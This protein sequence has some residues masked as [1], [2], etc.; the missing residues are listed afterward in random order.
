MFL[1][2]RSN[3]IYYIH[4]FQENGKRTCVSTKSKTKS[5][6]LKFLSDFQRELSKK[7]LAGV[8]FKTI[9]QFRLEYIRYSESIHRPK[10]TLR[11]KGI[12]K[13]F[14]IFCGDIGL[15]QITKAQIESYLQVKVKVSRYS[16]QQHLAYLRSSF[17]KAIKDG[18]LLSNP[19][20]LVRN[21]KL[22]EK[23]PVFI[24]KI[25]FQ[26]LLGVIDNPDIKDIVIFAANTGLRQMELLTL[27]WSQ[28]NLIDKF[29]ILDNIVHTTKS[30]KVRVVP[31]NLAAMQILISRNRN[32]N[33]EFIF[34]NHAKK[35]NADF[36]TKKFKK[37]IIKAGLNPQLKFHS[38][39]HSFASWLVQNGVPLYD[40]SKLLGHADM[41]TTQIYSH[42]RAEDLRS[43]INVLNN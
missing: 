6:A 43:A 34:A 4:Y 42:L 40:V 5:E 19:F 9:T 2:K 12:L 28:I 15:T 11:V 3:G 41:K 20:Q 10:T 7:K 31:L 37:Y 16:A 38:L 25:S 35:I 27:T 8:I 13:E 36:L 22:P 32:S 21:Y 39:R 23:Q 18:Y 30:K 1:S 33:S 26:I 24:D 14:A 29:L 17:N